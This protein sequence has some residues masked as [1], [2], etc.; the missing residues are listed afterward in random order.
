MAHGPLP[1]G[2]ALRSPPL[3]DG[4]CAPYA[5]SGISAAFAALSPPSGQVAHAFLAL[6]PLPRGVLLH[7]A[8]VRLACLIHAA[9]VRSEPESNSQRK[10]PRGAA[11]AAPRVF[12]LQNRLAQASVFPHPLRAV[13]ASPGARLSFRFSQI[14]RACRGPGAVLGAGW[15]FSTDASPLSTP[16]RKKLSFAS[17]GPPPAGPP[18]VAAPGAVEEPR[19]LAGPPPPVN[20]PPHTFLTFFFR[21]AV[22]PAPRA[23]TGYA[24]CQEVRHLTRPRPRAPAATSHVRQR[25]LGLALRFGYART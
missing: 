5:T 23:V 20:P 9:S 19:T 16:A 25:A 10:I 6:P 24:R 4:A 12:R 14:V 22:G 11:E 21:A 17:P 3:A 13:W 7:R 8:T 15:D 1:R 18:G 2:R